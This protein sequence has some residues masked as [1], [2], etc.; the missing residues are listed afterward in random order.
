MDEENIR[1]HPTRI[2]P[3]VAEKPPPTDNY[4]AWYC[5]IGGPAGVAG[6]YLHNRAK[7]VV[8]E[9]AYETPQHEVGGALV[10]GVYTDRGAGDR[11]Y[12]E[13]TDAVRGDFTQ[14]SSA[15]LTFTPDT[16]SQIVS[17]VEAQFEGKRI[18]GWYHTHPGH[19]VF[20]S[21]P[22]RFIQNVC[23]KRK[24]EPVTRQ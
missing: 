3:M 13:V 16:W 17:E 12:I 1:V 5:E 15:R 14:G 22:E 10:G 7:Q 11:R 9:H 24:K 18:V 20:L 8:L 19:G 2:E 4:D 6:I 21:G 23:S